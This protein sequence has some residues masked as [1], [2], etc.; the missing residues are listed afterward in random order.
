MDLIDQAI[1]L[2]IRRSFFIF[3]HTEPALSLLPQIKLGSL[4]FEAKTNLSTISFK[5]L[6]FGML[7]PKESI[8]KI[9][10][11]FLLAFRKIS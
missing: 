7:K 8:Q 9:M 3:K 10:M 6:P 5:T 4:S 11:F 2:A 1:D